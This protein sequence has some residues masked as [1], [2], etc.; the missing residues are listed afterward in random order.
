MTHSLGHRLRTARESKGLSLQDVAHQS[1]IPVPR[2]RDLEEDTYTTF[3]SLTY[4]RTFLKDYAGRMGIDAHE[5]LDEMHAPPLGGTQDYSY[6]VRNYGTWTRS[7]RRSAGYDNSPVMVK[8][9]SMGMVAA[10]CGAVLL[11]GMGML[12]GAAFV[13]EKKP[14]STLPKEPA[15]EIRL[16]KTPSQPETREAPFSPPKAL[17]A[18]EEKALPA[19]PADV[20]PA[21]K[22]NIAPGVIP[23]ALP[24]VDVPPKAAKAQR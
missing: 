7:R 19:T 21:K 4:A 24:V 20:A 23:K 2:L 11:I 13:G 10:I 16:A 6:L 18:E 1:R 3:G 17:P 5:I 15:I 14:V 8:G 9:R 12:L 22:M